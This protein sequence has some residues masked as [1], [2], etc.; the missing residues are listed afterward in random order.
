MENL[1]MHFKTRARLPWLRQFGPSGPQ[2]FCLHLRLYSTS[3]RKIPG[4]AR[5]D[6]IWH[7]RS[8]LRRPPAGGEAL[9]EV[10]PNAEMHQL[11]S[12]HFAVSPYKSM[13]FREQRRKC[14][15][16]IELVREFEARALP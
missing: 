8:R 5:P 12:G 1:D 16:L 4:E 7:V 9:L 3:D 6:H 14:S 11:Q 13:T 15:S 10:L 2:G